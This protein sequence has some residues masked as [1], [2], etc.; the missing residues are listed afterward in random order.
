MTLNSQIVIPIFRLMQKLIPDMLYTPEHTEGDKFFILTN[1][2]ARNYKV[3]EC[4]MRYTTTDNWKDVIPHR[5]DVFINEIVY[6]KNFKVLEEAS[7]GLTQLHVI[8][9]GT[10]NYIK[11]EEPAYYVALGDNPEYNAD[12]VR[13]EYA[14]L[15]SPFSVYDYSINSG[16]S[17]LRK[18]VDVPNYNKMLYATE[19]VM[20]TARDGKKIPLTIAYRKDKLIK[21]GTMPGFIYGYGSYGSSNEDYF[22]A[23]IF[24]LLDRGFIYAN[25]HIRGGQEMGGEWYEE[26]KMLNKKNTFYDFIDCSTWLIENKYVAKDGLFANGLSAGGLLMGAVVTM[27]PD[28]YR[29]VIADVPFVDVLSTMEDETIPLT[30]FEWLE[31]GNPA[32]KEQYEYMKSYSPYDNVAA[33]AYPAMLVTT[34]LHDSQVQYWEPAKWVAKLRYTKT[35]NNLLL[36]KTNMDAGHGGKSGRYEYLK[37]VAFMYAFILNEWKK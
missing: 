13:Y 33:T 25:T 22:D 36:L 17:V 20:V 18:T 26:G 34:G 3:V 9:N 19:R 27:R 2:K 15:I 31:W 14:S 35:D 23:N 4:G 11:F 24:T 28:L 1:Y 30:S 16:E 6:F 29:G 5:P 21:N 8:K 37:E 12:F 7:N 32:I 10:E